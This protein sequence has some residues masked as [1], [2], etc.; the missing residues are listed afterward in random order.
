MG[1]RETIQHIIDGLEKELKEQRGKLKALPPAVEE[2][3]KIIV[4]LRPQNDL[5]R[6]EIGQLQHFKDLKVTFPYSFNPTN[7]WE[8]PLYSTTTTNRQGDVSCVRPTS[9]SNYRPENGSLFNA[10]LRG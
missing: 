3:Q 5:L 4:D 1:E 6:R 2:L 10:P 8:G 9:E 7:P